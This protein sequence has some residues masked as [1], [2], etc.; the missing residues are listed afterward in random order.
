MKAAITTILIALILV[1]AGCK[2]DQD[3]NLA[4]GER[5]TDKEMYERAMKYIRKDPEK[6]RLLFK[7]IMQVYPA[8]VYSKKA[9]IGIA[10]S[11]FKQKDAASLVVAS[12]EYQEYV[13]LYPQSPDAVYAKFQIGMCY[14]NQMKQPGRDQSNTH[15]T[16]KAFENLVKQYPGTEE[17]EQAKE[18]IAEARQ[19]L[20]T[21][22]FRIGYYNYKY[23]A[24]RGAVARFK[25]VLDDYPDFKE[26]DK[27][28][29][30]TGKSYYALKEFDSALSFFQQVVTQFPQSK[31]A[32]KASRLI[33]KIGKETS[34]N[35]E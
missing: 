35:V 32:K 16:I 10:D 33:Q 23:N 17:A 34:Q 21:H 30:Y 11:Y 3:V 18:I 7:E 27:L 25:Q 13:N 4:P 2:K 15:A 31:H 26:M 9:K 19:T 6:A 20:A 24:Y 29:Y 5:G 22:Y 12:A 1:S 14:K 8:S 28:F